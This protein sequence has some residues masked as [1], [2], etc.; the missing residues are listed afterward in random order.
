MG[1]AFFGGPIAVTIVAVMN[2]VYLGRLKSEWPMIV[3]V[4]ALGAV[5]VYVFGNYVFDGLT[6][7][8]SFRLAARGAGFVSFGAAWLIHR[9]ELRALSTLGIEPR[10]PWIPVIAACLVAIATHTWIVTKLAEAMANG[11]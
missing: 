3:G 11:V 5:A 10:S 4:F 7:T 8:R 1:A 6:E 2:S 9:K